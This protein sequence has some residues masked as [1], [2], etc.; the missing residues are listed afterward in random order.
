MKKKLLIAVGIVVA[1]LTIIIIAIPMFVDVNK[2]KPTLETDLTNALGRKVD[3]G[4]IE[5][6]IIS[7]GVKLDDVS[8]ADDPAFSHSPFLQTKQLTV[9]VALIPLIF[10]K[11]IEVH[12]FTITDPQVSLLRSASGTW[13]FS[14]LG[15]GPKTAAKPT[16]AAESSGPP[17]NLSIEKLTVSNG[18]L[19]VGMAEGHGK[20]RVYTNVDFEASDFSSTSQF[21]FKLTAK[22]PSGGT[23]KV[24]GKAGPVDAADAAMTPLTAKIDVAD[25][26]LASTGFV[27]S[28]SGIGGI[29]DFNGDA[30][31]DGH[32][33]TSKGTVKANK[34]KIAPAGKPATIPVNVDYETVYDLKRQTGT[35][36]QG[37]IHIGKAVAHLTGNYNTAGTTATLQMKFNGQAIPIADLDGVL[38]AAG[39]TLPSG[40]SLKSGSL[41]IELAISGPVDKLVITGPVN[42]SNAVIGGYSLKSKLGA[43]GPFAG[44]GGGGGGSD[45]EIQSL[46]TNLHVD[47]SGT[48]ANDL[49]VVVPSIG[50]VT[51]NANVSS[52]DQLDCKMSAKLAG[53]MGAMTSVMSM[54]GGKNSN[55]GGIPFMIK[56]TTSNP[57]FVPDVGGMAGGAV[58]GIPGDATGIAG[59]ATK[60]AGG[61]VGGLFGK[62]K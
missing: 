24:D 30:S 49:N 57:I 59:G 20:T 11:T 51:G 26:D 54:G 61:V 14:T 12:S 36:K 50:T 46:T 16:G 31:S 6:S 53:G 32:Q 45:T 22:A 60:G 52:T 21:P 7:G 1:L 34:L 62:K 39:I 33:V 8:I 17:S 10:S 23:L 18:T 43:L 47:P 4:N 37:D 56:G 5:L 9:G 40:A 41:N 15:K 13:N 42:L 58:K 35:L 3:V 25:L 48:Q 55:S 44:L 2:F 38:P 27:D 19:S 28:S 29:V